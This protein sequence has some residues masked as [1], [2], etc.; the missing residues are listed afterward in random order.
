MSLTLCGKPWKQLV[1]ESRNIEVIEL[2]AT[3]AEF[4]AAQSG[5]IS[6]R[7]KAAIKEA[8]GAIRARG[9]QPHSTVQIRVKA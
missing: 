9:H 4:E 2:E 6:D 8:A 3:D 1:A 7:L 5:A